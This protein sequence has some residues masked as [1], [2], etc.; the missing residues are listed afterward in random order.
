MDVE[1]QSMNVDVSSV[2]GCKVRS[3]GILNN[4]WDWRSGL[5]RL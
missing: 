2:L 5:I 4:T 3:S 1:G